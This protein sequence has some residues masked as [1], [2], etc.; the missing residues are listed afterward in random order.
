MGTQNCLDCNLVSE[1][2]RKLSED[3][4]PARRVT[5]K[6]ADEMRE[7][8]HREPAGLISP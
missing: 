3:L 8:H 5:H 7:E 2:K 1:S 4:P 6:I